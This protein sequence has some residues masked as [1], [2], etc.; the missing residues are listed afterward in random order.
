MIDT[1][2]LRHG[3][4]W[5]RDL[6]SPAQPDEARRASQPPGAGEEGPHGDDTPVG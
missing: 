4:S 1:S 5:E 2:V 6:L 3:S